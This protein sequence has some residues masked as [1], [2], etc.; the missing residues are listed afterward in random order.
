MG[1]TD[2][3]TELEDKLKGVDKLLVQSNKD[4]LMLKSSLSG[5]NAFVS[6]KNYEII[7]RFL[8]GTGAWKVLNKAKAT[9]LTM[10]QLVSVQERAALQDNLRMKE[11]AKI[12]KDRK[13]LLKLE[14]KFKEVS[15]SKDKELI[16]LLKEKSDV[17]AASATM[18]GDDKAIAEILKRISKSK[19][20]LDNVL[21]KS[22]ISGKTLV[23]DETSKNILD[24][25]VVQTAAIT[26]GFFLNQKFLKKIATSSAFLEEFKEEQQK[27]LD[28]LQA[29]FNKNLLENPSGPK[30]EFLSHASKEF[31]VKLE[32][33][34]LS[35]VDAQNILEEGSKRFKNITLD[36]KELAKKGLDYVTN[37]VDL[38]SEDY[39]NRLAAIEANKN[40]LAASNKYVDSLLDGK[41]PKSGQFL[42]DAERHKRLEDLAPRTQSGKFRKIDP[43]FL[44]LQKNATD[45][46][47][48]FSEI[49]D[50]RK[51]ERKQARA[52][53]FGFGKTD[54]EKE[55]ISETLANRRKQFK[56]IWAKPLLKMRESIQ[57][58]GGFFAAMGEW[59]AKG[60][61]KLV[62]FTGKLLS[63]VKKTFIYFGVLLIT[64]FLLY[65]LFKNQEFKE[66][67]DKIKE[68]AERFFYSVLLPLLTMV[69]GG[70]EKIYDGFKQGELWMVLEGLGQ[71]LIGLISISFAILGKALH[72]LG[73]V[74]WAAV[75]TYIEWFWENIR[76]NT[77]KAIASVLYIAAGIAFIIAFF[78]GFPAIVVGAI[79][80]GLAYLIDKFS[81][82]ASGGVVGSGM[83]LVGEKGPELVKLPSGSRVHSNVDS[84]KMLSG[85]TTNNITI[86]VTGRVGASD[87]EIKDIANKLSRELNNRMNRTGSAVSGF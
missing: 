73:Q 63:F 46:Q 48:D 66:R 65:R 79:L 10:I 17:F 26:G 80:L 41:D 56:L 38:S 28:A 84:R 27:K 2:E 32:S 18:V 34:T 20:L 35:L 13:E 82:F 86:Q 53:A 40:I 64:F 59:A 70:L 67:L 19:G 43:Q 30:M 71:I 78:V 74:I 45:L 62:E 52:R 33:T 50:K 15:I 87:S 12:I 25:N 39:K 37:I 44:E 3:I 47:K 5:I 76:S 55:K 9:V 29:E 7:S 14:S 51:T 6:G 77:S 85:G 16:E 23:E 4:A 57:E 69:W 42:S 24:S 49:L 58:N 72:I 60:G 36:P 61:T 75:Q 68:G 11:M 54:E 81:P 1:I 22:K 21:G 8:S 83:Q 31:G